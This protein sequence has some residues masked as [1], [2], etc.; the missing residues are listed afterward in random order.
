[1]AVTQ[2]AIASGVSVAGLSRAE[3]FDRMAAAPTYCT[4]A[5]GSAARSASTP[6]PGHA[7]VAQV[8]VGQ[9]LQI[10][11]ARQAGVGDP[12]PVE[13]QTTELF[14]AFEYGQA[15]VGRLGAAPDSAPATA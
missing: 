1:M 15:L 4:L 8:D 10:L 5:R 2:A 6:L 9:I 3:F 7:A 13:I 12:R 11:Q 14:H